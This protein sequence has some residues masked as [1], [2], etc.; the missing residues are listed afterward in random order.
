MSA[1]LLAGEAAAW[2]GGLLRQGSPASEFTGVSIDTRTLAAGELFVA[3]AG[4]NHDAHGFLA[5]AAAAGAGGLAILRGRALPAE[6]KPELPVIEVADTT[7][8]L[9]ALAAGHRARFRG[10][11]VAITGSNGKTT[12]KEM[13]AAILGWAAPCLKTQGN[14][15]N[16]FG[17]PLTLLRRR[18]SDRALV[19]E[20]GM[21]HRGEIAPLAAIARPTVGVVTN[22]GSA[23]VEHL[24]S[25]EAIALE[26]G[27]LLAALPADGAAVIP[28]DDGFGLAGRTRARIVRFGRGVDADVR[29]EEVRTLETGGFA[30]QLATPGGSVAARVAGLGEA[31]LSNALAAAAAAQAAGASLEALAAGLAGYQP[32]HGRLERIELGDGIVLLDDTYNANPQS[33]EMALRVLAERRGRGRGLAVLGEMGELGATA[34]QA[35]RDVGRL[36]GSLG[37]DRLYA[38][39]AF[40]SRFAEGASAAGMP[41][42]RIAICRDHDEL[43]ERVARELTPLDW[44]LVKGSRSAR[45]ERVVER[46]AA[47]G[48]D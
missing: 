1:Q 9:G 8:A 48:K 28:A 22:V 37:I 17:V 16:E 27:D 21:N 5:K 23:H 38:L 19:V 47:R 44:V 43:A 20:I 39:G 24:G 29:A 26:K 40:A 13:C 30:F 11:V 12:T 7:K 18:E 15:N 4:P 3:I 34:D 14:L 41:A 31:T 25:R 35:H 2:M 33:M 42:E 36:V 46:L 6:L 45:M 10:P 32:A